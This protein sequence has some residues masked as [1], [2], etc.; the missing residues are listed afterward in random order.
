MIGHRVSAMGDRALLVHCVGNDDARAVASA[1]ATSNEP[2]ALS[3]DV[4]EDVVPAATSVLVVYSR[5]GS[6]AARSQAIARTIARAADG[7]LEASGEV[8]L[9]TRYDG[10]DLR[11]VADHAGLSPSALIELHASTEYRVAFLGFVPGFAYLAGAPERLRVPRRADPRISVPA[12]S[13]AVANDM[14]A[15]Y[16]RASPGGWQLIGS[17]HA[18]LF[19]PNREPPSLLTV[20]TRV[21]FVPT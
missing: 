5:P 10:P 13:V 11:L 4:V 3:R 1:I 18:S 20:G 2:R 21:R 17:T 16:P 8:S 14:T 12:G 15:V 7:E 19:D 9:E 6:V